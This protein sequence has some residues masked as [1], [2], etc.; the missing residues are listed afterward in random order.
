MK[1]AFDHHAFTMQRYGGISRYYFNFIKEFIKK[2]NYDVAIYCGFY[3]NQYLTKLPKKNV[4]GFRI[5]KYPKYSKSFLYYVNSYLSKNGINNWKPDIFHET[6]YSNFKNNEKINSKVIISTAYDMIHEKFS[7]QI[8]NSNIISKNKINSFRR[9][10]H[11]ISISKN[12]KKDLIEIFGIDKNKI[13]VVYPI[14]DKDSFIKKKI[15]KDFSSK[16]FLLYVGERGG[17]KNFSNFIEAFSK[18][19]IRN[20]FDIIAFGGNNFN[21]FEKKLIKSFGLS[22]STVKQVSGDDI[23]LSKYY[24]NANSLVFL[25]AFFLWSLFL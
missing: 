3:Q 4:R 21:D 22:L 9:A 11:I 20:D 23:L 12:T 18:S 13:S 2:E 5:N 16:P 8:P 15:N 25:H 7:K 19:K 24:Q 14:F 1:L 6:Y 10:D 17:Y